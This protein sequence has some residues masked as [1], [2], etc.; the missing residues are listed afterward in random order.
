MATARDRPPEEAAEDTS[1]ARGLRLLLT[2]A[3]RGEIRADELSALLDMPISTAYRYLRTLADFGFVDKHDGLYRLG[4]RLLI[5]PGSTVTSERLM[6]LADPVL[7]MLVEETGETAVVMRR[8]GLSAVCLHEVEG[9]NALRVTLEPGSTS[10]LYAGAMCR[11][12][13]AFAPSEIVD[14]VIDQGMP[15]LH[16][17]TPAPDA[18]RAGLEQIVST[19]MATSEGELISGTVAIAVPIMREDG[20][21]GSLAVIGPDARCGLAWRARVRK[22]LPAAA[23]A[24]TAALAAQETG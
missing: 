22:L 17:D 14:A 19:G 1:F 5:G 21:V 3:D 7:R 13:L 16:P 10:P 24:I 9:K 18:L 12:L 6:R 4:P 23:G 2:V 20:I 8:V 15:P 11:V